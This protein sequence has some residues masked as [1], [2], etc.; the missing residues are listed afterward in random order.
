[1]ILTVLAAVAVSS[2]VLY[3]LGQQLRLEELQEARARW[4]AKGPRDYR[5][6][7]T[8]K[9]NDEPVDRYAVHVRGGKIELATVNGK[10]VPAGR[11][12]QVDMDGLFGLIEEHLRLRAQPDQPKTFLRAHFDAADGHVRSYVR[13]PRGQDRLEITMALLEPL[14][15]R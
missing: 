5:L 4:Q 7:Y 11:R 1:L 3:N 6:A 10:P 12:A 15:A 14:P 8:M 9:K 2:L 13:A